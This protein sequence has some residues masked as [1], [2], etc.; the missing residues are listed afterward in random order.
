MYFV[1]SASKSV[2]CRP[3]QFLCKNESRCISRALQCNGQMD[4]TDRSDEE[5]CGM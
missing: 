2:Q 1:I 5:D 4:C 3:D